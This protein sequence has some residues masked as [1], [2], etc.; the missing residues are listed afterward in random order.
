MAESF[1]ASIKRELIDRRPLL[2]SPAHLYLYHPVGTCCIGTDDQA[3]V[4]IELRGPRNGGTKS[5]RRI[6]HAFRS[7][8]DDNETKDHRPRRLGAWSAGRKY[9]S[10][11]AATEGGPAAGGGAS[12]DSQQGTE[13]H[14]YWQQV[15][16]ELVIVLVLVVAALSVLGALWLPQEKGFPSVPE[17]LSVDIRA[18]GVMAVTET[19]ARTADGGSTLTIEQEDVPYFEGPGNEARQRWVVSVGDLG[20]GHVCTPPYVVVPGSPPFNFAIPVARTA[21]L[22]YAKTDPS[23]PPLT[24]V[25]GR[26]VLL[27]EL[28][29]YSGGPVGL[30]GAYLS[31]WLPPEIDFWPSGFARG[32]A[33]LQVPS[34]E[35]TRISRTLEPNTGDT[36]NFTVQSQ[37]APNASTAS[38]WQWSTTLSATTGVRVS[39]VNVSTSQRGTYLSFLSGIAFGIAG[40]AVITILQ[41][42]LGPLSRRRDKR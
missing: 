42:L 16:I 1:F 19:L 20:E 29:W 31:A 32:V 23:E 35:V 21:P 30:D 14:P 10:V 38:S 5:S 34:Q 39:A 15:H 28:C 27:V 3:V 33:A 8:M 37:V 12:G 41:E 13:R 7:Q 6:G 9:Y 24:W 36:A 4:D 18:T 11:M 26:G 25:I 22:F 17:D 40:G 2:P